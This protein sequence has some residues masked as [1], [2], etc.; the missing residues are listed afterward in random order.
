MKIKILAERINEHL[1]VFDQVIGSDGVVNLTK[2]NKNDA[3]VKRFGAQG[4]VYVGDAAVEKSIWRRAVDALGVVA[5]ALRVHHWAKN[6]LV[7]LPILLHG[8]LTEWHTWIQGI[9]A[10]TAL[11]LAASGTY[12]I[13]DMLDLASDRRHPVKRFRPLAAGTLSIS[14]GIML[15]VL[16]LVSAVALSTL[17]SV[18]CT[19]LVAAYAALSLF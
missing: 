8:H 5:R 9:I 11:S 12:L 6:V 13:N 15:V 19:A 18:A 3:L 14:A 2:A 4:F 17:L 10:A 7:L 1:H 16:L